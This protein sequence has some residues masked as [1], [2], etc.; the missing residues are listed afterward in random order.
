MLD[1]EIKILKE[2]DELRDH[3]DKWGA[4][5]DETIW[6]IFKETKWK[7]E[8]KIKPSFRRKDSKSYLSKALWRNK[9]KYPNPIL[10]IEDK[11]GTRLVLLKSDDINDVGDILEKFDGWSAKC[12]KLSDAGIEDKPKEFNYRSLHIVVWPK[13]DNENYL[14]VNKELL[15]CE[16]QIRTLLQ[17]AFAE[18]SH[19]STYKGPFRNDTDILRMLSKSMALMEATDEYFCKLFEMMTNSQRKIKRYIEEL[20]SLYKK[21]NPAYNNEDLDIG[22][23]DAIFE[24]LDKKDIAIDDIADFA[25]KNEQSLKNSIT[26]NQ[27]TLFKQP[28]ALLIGYYLFNWEDFIKKEWPLTTEALKTALRGFGYSAY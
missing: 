28:V 19:D 14:G 4:F 5:V 21:F 7:H 13:E 10:D 18:I 20:T 15:T 1:I 25:S 16:I 23:T 8:I 12:T 3:L 22:M 26:G 2:F 17:H 11:V 6:L 24:L 9:D 27:S